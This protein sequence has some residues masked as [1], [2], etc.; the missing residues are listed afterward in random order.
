MPGETLKKAEVTTSESKAKP[1]AKKEINVNDLEGRVCYFSLSGNLALQAFES[2]NFSTFPPDEKEQRLRQELLARL[3]FAILMFDKVVMHCSDPLRSKLVLEI[4]EQHVHWIESGKIVFIISKHIGNIQKDFERYIRSKISEYSR[5]YCSKKEAISLKQSHIDRPYYKRVKD[6]LDKSPFIVRKSADN[7]FDSLVLSDLSSQ[8]QREQV[9]IDPSLDVHQILSLSLSLYQLL[10]ARALNYKK[11]EPGTGEFIFPLPVVNEVTKQIQT[12]LRQKNTIARSAIDDSIRERLKKVGLTNL[13]ESI[14]ESISLR[15]DVL[16]CHMN[17]GKQMI[18]EFHPSYEQRSM[19]QA[20]CFSEYLN[21]IAQ[22]DK[23]VELDVAKIDNM[24]NSP[25]LSLFRLFYLACMA[26]M[27]EYMNLA[28]V[29]Y[30]VYKDEM[31]KVFSNTVTK[32]LQHFTEEKFVSMR[33]I[34]N[35]VEIQ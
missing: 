30:S 27:R 23:I 18:L 1:S 29:E 16:Y 9:I 8:F 35:E 3:Y 14:L 28:E 5:G 20:N 32:H 33:N 12:H 13:Q 21:L 11:D 25:D 10:H 2:M 24:L 7:S 26:D 34:L 19:Y 6:L 15:M 22:S 17:S 31:Q 4:L